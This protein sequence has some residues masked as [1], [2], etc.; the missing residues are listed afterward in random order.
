MSG[1]NP[2]AIGPFSDDGGPMWFSKMIII[3]GT[4]GDW[5]GQLGESGEYLVGRLRVD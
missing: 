1:W 4:I 2:L 3:V 5:A